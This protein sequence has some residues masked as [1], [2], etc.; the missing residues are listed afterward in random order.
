MADTR[1]SSKR[2]L[3]LF[4]LIGF[5]CGS[6]L[7]YL[8]ADRDR[9]DAGIASLQ[10]T[11]S[12][13]QTQLDAKEIELERL[14]HSKSGG[15]VLNAVIKNVPNSAVARARDESENTNEQADDEAIAPPEALDGV[16]T[17]KDLET[18]SDIDPRPFADKLKDFLAENVDAE[19]AAVASRGI[20]DMAKDR[21]NLPDYALQSLYNKQSDPNLKRVIAQVLSQRGNNFLLDSQIA[22]TQAQLKSDQPADRQAALN[23]LAKIRSVKAVDVI[24]PY[25]Q[26]ADTNVKL[27]ALQALRETGN[28]SHVALIQ[29]L[30]NDPDP[31]VSSLATEVQNQLKNLSSTARATISSSDIEATLPPLPNS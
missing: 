28:Q 17:L 3:L 26:D 5:A 12:S 14:R 15:A 18:E 19:K 7:I 31:A 27:D 25:L 20:F 16:M 23:E 29:T 21:E 4:T 24:V 13:L 9:G 11:I 2:Q 30:V 10:Q 1:G 22:E 6:G 8:M